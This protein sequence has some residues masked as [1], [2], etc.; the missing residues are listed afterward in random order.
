[1]PDPADLTHGGDAVAVYLGVI[2]ESA[3]SGNIN[4]DFADIIAAAG[5]MGYFAGSGDLGCDHGAAESLG[6]AAGFYYGVAVY[7]ATVEDANMFVAAYPGE[8][9]GIA[10]ITTFCLD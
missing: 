3:G 10:E 5:A 4:D 2:E 6:L 9:V 1:L 8:V 7:F